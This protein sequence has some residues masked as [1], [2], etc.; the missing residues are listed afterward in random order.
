MPPFTVTPR[1]PETISFGRP[2]EPPLVGA[3]QDGAMASGRSLSSVD[4]SNN[5][6]AD[7]TG[8]GDCIGASL[9]TMGGLASSTIATSSPA[10]S[11]DDTGCGVAPIFQ[12]A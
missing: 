8:R 9:T 5:S 3:F 10:G 1:E 11:F 12:Q 7:T 4:A 2:V 6:C